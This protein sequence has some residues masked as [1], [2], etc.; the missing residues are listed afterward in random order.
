MLAPSVPKTPEE[1][2]LQMIRTGIEMGNLKG[3][4]QQEFTRILS[5]TDQAMLDE[6][7]HGF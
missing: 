3:F 1:T 6:E 2:I 4:M 7:I 5:N